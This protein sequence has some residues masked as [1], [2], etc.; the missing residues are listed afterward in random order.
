M[1]MVWGVECAGFEWCQSF[2]N[3]QRRL[4]KGSVMDLDMLAISRLAAIKLVVFVQVHRNRGK[5]MAH[6]LW[7][8]VSVLVL[9][10]LASTVVATPQ[11]TNMNLLAT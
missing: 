9:L 8:L 6:Q 3:L 4:Q 2:C 11:G 5:I 1:V 7:S 10:S